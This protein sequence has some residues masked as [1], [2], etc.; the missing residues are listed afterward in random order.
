[1][2][3]SASG[4]LLQFI[5][6][7]RVDEQTELLPDRSLL[8]RV[9]AERDDAAFEAILRRHGPTVLSV[10]R[11]VLANDTDAEDAFQATDLLVAVH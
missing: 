7:V 8:E 11:G 3:E 10:C 6:Q 1:M 5:R 9:L 2:T 4:S